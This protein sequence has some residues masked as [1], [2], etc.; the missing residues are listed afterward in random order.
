MIKHS[1]NLGFLWQ[2]HDLIEGVRAAAKAGFVAVECHFPFETPAQ[3]VKD[4]LNETGLT[5]ISLNTYPG[6]REKGDF[7]VC[8]DPE[9]ITEAHQV[10]D[11]ALEY[12]SLINTPN[13]HVMAGKIDTSANQQLAMQTFKDNL[14]YAANKADSLGIQVLIEPI[15]NIDVPDY[16]VGD[17]DRA[18]DILNSLKLSNLKIMFDCY[19]IQKVHGELKKNLEQYL[20]LIGHIQIASFPKRNEP[21]EG[22]IDYSDLF[23]FIDELGYR[24]FIGAEYNPRTTTDE[25]LAWLKHS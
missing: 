2:E 25:G 23:N 22:E 8:A 13:V 3:D 18:V 4:V 14:T 16:F 10:I 15:N 17:L 12:A 21:D 6:D 1:A 9:R 20:D 19:H 5:M 7:G 24:G 11:Q